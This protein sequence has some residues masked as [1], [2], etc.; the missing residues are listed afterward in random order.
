MDP[1]RFDLLSRAVATSTTRRRAFSLLAAATLGWRPMR[2]VAAQGG[3]ACESGLTYCPDAAAC[4][5]LLTD[6]NHC[7]ACGAV[8]E[9]QLVPVA[10]RGG[11]CVRANCPEGVEYCGAVD[12]CRDLSSDPAHCGACQNPCAS[13]VCSLGACAPPGGGCPEGQVTCDG[14]CVATCCNNQHCGTCGNACA[15][16]LT[17]FEGICDCPSG[18]CPPVTLPNTGSGTSGDGRGALW[19]TLAASGAALAAVGWR[20]GQT[21]GAGERRGNR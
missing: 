7:G 16:P 3:S 10:C 8:C 20:R 11:E 18:N 17:C 21:S 2:A 14:A 9:S 1:L 15:P 12:G 19:A 4:V 6:L 13:G 5:D